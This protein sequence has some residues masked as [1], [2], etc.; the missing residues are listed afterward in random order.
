[1]QSLRIG[2]DQRLGGGKSLGNPWTFV[3]R[4]GDRGEGLEVELDDARAKRFC[5]LNVARES[6]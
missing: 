2:L 6:R 5:E 3:K 1:M 4:A